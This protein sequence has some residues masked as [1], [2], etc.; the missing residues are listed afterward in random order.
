MWGFVCVCAQI[1]PGLGS[2]LSNQLLR[3]LLQWE[4]CLGEKLRTFSLPLIS[5]RLI[6]EQHPADPPRRL[7]MPHL[8][9]LGAVSPVCDHH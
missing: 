7:E 2:L 8:G 4:F 6:F 3:S 1:N 9:V 5:F